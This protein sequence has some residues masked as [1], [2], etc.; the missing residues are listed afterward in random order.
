[1]DKRI[2]ILLIF[3]TIL[4]FCNWSCTSPTDVQANR[5]V[6]KDVDFT[7]EQNTNVLTTDL[8]EIN[9]ND[10]SY[11]SSQGRYFSL[12][13]TSSKAISI[14]KIEFS[15]YKDMFSVTN[16]SFP[17]ILEPKDKDSSHREILVTF[18]AKVVGE[19]IDTLKINNLSSPKLKLI[20]AVPVVDATDSDFGYH[21]VKQSK[22]K[23][24]VYIFNNSNMD[25]VVT[26]YKLIDP[27]GVF[28]V[29]TKIP[30]T[31][32]PHGQQTI[33]IKFTP[34]EAKPY[35]A[36]IE[37]KIEGPMGYIDNTSVLIGTGIN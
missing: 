33:I 20:A 8:A 11:Q 3:A 17:F 6:E 22:V 5:V 27:E 37:F 19:F 16:V 31:I 24:P 30:V 35:N 28:E 2:I 23:P 36:R 14:D 29:L 7:N 10:V 13:N 21:T 15:K 32:A 34:K 26:D 12:I 25:A 18:N 4:A 1:M 9:F